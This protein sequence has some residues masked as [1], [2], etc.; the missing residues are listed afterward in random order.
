MKN[1]FLL[2]KIPHE[3]KKEKSKELN[4]V[5]KFHKASGFEFYGKFYFGYG[6]V[7]FWLHLEWM[8]DCLKGFWCEIHNRKIKM[9]KNKFL[10]FFNLFKKVEL[11][12][13]KKKKQKIVT[14]I[15]REA[16]RLNVELIYSLKF[17]FIILL[18]LHSCLRVSMQLYIIAKW[19]LRFLFN[20]P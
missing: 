3:Q 5:F 10:L 16:N 11:H 17:T 15:I 6:T 4:L 18:S 7:I 12:V 8:S 13:I 14:K 2:Q 20:F 19:F 1:D 9:D